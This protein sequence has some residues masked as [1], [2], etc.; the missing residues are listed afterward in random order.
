[1]DLLAE[2]TR[3]YNKSW[4]EHAWNGE[5][6]YPVL[7]PHQ[8]ILRDTP[9]QFSVTTSNITQYN[10]RG[11]PRSGTKWMQRIMELVSGGKVTHGHSGT[12]E[13]FKSNQI[14]AFICR[15]VRDSIISAY[16]Y[17]KSGKAAGAMHTTTASLNKMTQEEGI[18][19]MIIMYMKYRMPFLVYWFNQ[20]PLDQIIKI[21]Y[22]GLI[23]DRRKCIL[24]IAK[25]IGKE[26]KPDKLQ[27][28]MRET[29]FKKMSK[30][31]IPG[32]EDKRHHYRKGII[33]DHKNYFTKQ[34]LDI[35]E[36]MGGN[37]LLI[38]LGYTP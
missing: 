5:K 10:V 31:R 2:Q 23:L 1:L 14:I 30:G 35:F 38:D 27:L 3:L 9:K 29:D 32:K 26:L 7:L 12:I 20:K 18:K 8:T 6:L 22:E 15:D 34:H 16:Y 17:I 37:E 19:Q 36:Q 28:I 21:R 24:N 11:S 13:Q 33:G 25:H 4:K